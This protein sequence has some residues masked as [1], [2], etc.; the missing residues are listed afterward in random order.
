MKEDLYSTKVFKHDG[1][2]LTVYQAKTTKNVLLFS[3][4]HATVDIGDD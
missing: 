3:T 2:T 1:S 4:M